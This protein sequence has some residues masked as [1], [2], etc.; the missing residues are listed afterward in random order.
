MHGFYNRGLRINLGTGRHD[1]F[2]IDDVLLARTLGGKGL[3]THYLLEETA[4]GCDPLGPDNAIIFATGPITGS[5]IWG[6]SRYGVYTKSPQTGL[7][8]ESYSGGHTPEFMDAAGYDIVIIKGAAQSPVWIDISDTDV[9]VLPADDLWGLDTFATEDA[10]RTKVMEA[11]AEKCGPVVIGPAAENLVRFAVVENDYWRSAGRTGVGTVLGAKMVKAVAFHGRARRSVADSVLLKEFSR[12]ITARAKE[13]K[14]VQVYR[15]VGT[16]GLVDLLNEAGAFPSRYWQRG[17]VDHR[18]GINSTALHTR[19]DVTPKACAKCLMACGRLSTVKEG[20]RAGLT[21]E[22]PE[23]ETIYAFG[24]LCE[25]R[26]IE[27]IIYLNDLCDRLGMDTITSGNLAGLA[28][29]ASRRGRIDLKL[30]Y[31]D[32]EGVAGLLRDIAAG[33]GI[34]ATLGQGIRHAAQVWG[35][36]DVSVHVKGLEPAGYDPR[37]LKGMGLAYA[38]SDRG[39]CHLRATFYKPELSGM[40]DPQTTTGKAGVFKVWEDRLTYFDMLILCRF[41]RDLYQWGELATITKCLTGLDLDEAEMVRMASAVA[42]DTRRFNIR[43]GLTRKDDELPLFLTE[44]PLPETGAAI[45]R[46][47]VSDMVEEYYQARGWKDGA[48]G[49]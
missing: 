14:G 33:R 46:R 29:E 6:S 12:S 4:P 27:D 15:K 10:V 13:D 3:A 43:E 9:R 16:T 35:M 11:C 48:P 38:T 2:A 47:E 19:C 30:D 40:V 39:A 21:V 8:S 7:Y 44:H 32:V 18:D 26:D 49:T 45:T 1:V 5:A 24:G 41:Y 28:I 36:E 31:G 37:A 34:G 42:D 20:P 23:Y 22:G 17:R 25:I